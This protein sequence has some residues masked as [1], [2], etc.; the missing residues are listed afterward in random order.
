LE[1]EKEMIDKGIQVAINT[2]VGVS[3]LAVV[4]LFML[5]DRVMNR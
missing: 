5:S 2:V 3:F 4:G 1:E